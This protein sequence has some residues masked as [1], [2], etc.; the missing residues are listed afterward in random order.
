MCNSHDSLVQAESNDRFDDRPWGD[1]Y[2][3][4]LRSDLKH[5]PID[6]EPLRREEERD[7]IQRTLEK[8]SDDFFSFRHEDSVT[9]M[10]QRTAKCS[11]WLKKRIFKCFNGP[12]GH[13]MIL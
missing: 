13:L 4:V 3:N 2:L 8:L 11:V 9:L 6:L 5:W 1:K 7:N 10:F 12:N